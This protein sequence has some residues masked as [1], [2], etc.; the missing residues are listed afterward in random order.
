V[1]ITAP[2]DELDL[3]DTI[4]DAFSKA[5][6]IVESVIDA[7]RAHDEVA[8]LAVTL[9]FA[10]DKLEAGHDAMEAWW[11]K[12]GQPAYSARRGQEA[13]Q[14]KVDAK[15]MTLQ[16]IAHLEALCKHDRALIRA[17]KRKGGNAR[18]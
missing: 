9:S 14:R 7:I 11:D 13:Q 2:K 6:A 17:Q 8:H 15:P 3:T 18:S 1:N 10:G 4:S 12:S 5:R 16:Q